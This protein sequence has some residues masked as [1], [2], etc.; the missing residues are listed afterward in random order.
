[1]MDRYDTSDLHR[2]QYDGDVGNAVLGSPGRAT[3]QRRRALL[4]PLGLAALG[5]LLTLWGPL[6][7]LGVVLTIG[8]VMGL[9]MNAVILLT[10]G[11]S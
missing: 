10:G 9:G 6:P 7:G 3:W 5:I 4:V 8:G 1:M 11:F 2:R